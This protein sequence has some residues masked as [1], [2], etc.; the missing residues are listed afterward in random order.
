VQAGDTANS[1]AIVAEQTARTTA[2]T[3]LANSVTTLAAQVQAGDTANSAAIVAEQTARTTADT[4]L[5]NSVTTLSASFGAKTGGYLNTDPECKLASAWV[6]SG[7]TV[8]TV[9]DGVAGV[10]A[11]VVTGSNEALTNTV[12]CTPGQVL[13]LEF[14][15]RKVSGAGSLYA[16][17]YL[18]DSAYTQLGYFIALEGV[19]LTASFALYSGA[20]TVPAGAVRATVG[21]TCNYTNSGVTQLQAVHWIDDSRAAG[22]SAA[23][24]S[25][26]TAQSSVNNSFAGTINSLQLQINSTVSSVTSEANIRGSTDG[27]LLA[28]YTVK[29]DTAGL[30]SGYGLASTIGTSPPQS[31]FGVRANSFYIAPPAVTSSTAPNSGL[32]NGF[33]WLD[34]GVATITTRYYN[35]GS[36]SLTPGNLP[37]IVQASPITINGQISPAGVYANNVFIQNGTIANAKIGKLQ[38]DDGHIA[39]LSVN[40]LVAGTLQVG[41]Y[42]QSANYTPG[43]SG[44]RLNG[45]GTS[46]IPALNIIGKLTTSQIEVGS[47]TAVQKFAGIVYDPGTIID[48]PAG[49]HNLMTVT[50]TGAPVFFSAS[51][52]IKVAGISVAAGA[53]SVEFHARLY[54]DDADIGASEAW[55]RSVLFP[56]SGSLM[57]TVTLPILWQQAIAAGSHN[58]AVYWYA[59]VKD[60]AGN[61]MVTTNTPAAQISSFLME[62]KV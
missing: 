59:W 52:N 17:I 36:W 20:L 14:Y 29:I 45:D 35:N 6:G 26:Q 12:A 50:T 23:V 1:A 40:K 18:F 5:A 13:R 19:A 8:Q 2:D 41:V 54:I 30:I 55:T 32:Y 38:V 47:V 21:I 31:T 16:R 56:N 43:V 10:S 3:A 24:Q 33:V 53:A 61:V 25:N 46:Q 4:A 44:W 42:A 58:F 60:S 27:F 51:I 15:A 48:T 37:F 9:A 49:Y 39:N 57:A 11:L 62:N 7:I 22:I 34:I 28:Q